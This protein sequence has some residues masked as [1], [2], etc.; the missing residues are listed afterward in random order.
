MAMSYVE[1]CNMVN[2]VKFF[3]LGRQRQDRAEVTFLNQNSK[4][5]RVVWEEL[6]KKFFY[7]IYFSGRFLFLFIPLIT[8]TWKAPPEIAVLPSHVRGVHKQA[9]EGITRQAWHLHRPR[10]SAHGF[11]HRCTI[12]IMINVKRA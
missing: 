12:I 1:H 7:F 4:L 11:Q 10:A 2:H 5:S 3:Y 8:P 9:T 6:L